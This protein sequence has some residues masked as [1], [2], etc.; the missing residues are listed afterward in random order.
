MTTPEQEDILLADL[1]S[2]PKRHDDY[3]HQWYSFDKWVCDDIVAELKANGITTTVTD[4]TLNICKIEFFS[5]LFNRILHPG[6]IY[7]I[8][9]GYE[10][11][12]NF[13]VTMGFVYDQSRNEIKCKT[14]DVSEACALRLIKYIKWVCSPDRLSTPNPLEPNESKNQGQREESTTSQNPKTGS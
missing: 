4:P 3:N 1:L 11:G 12:T 7:M 8:I 14:A 2:M 5:E 10:F 13:K 6:D 9:P